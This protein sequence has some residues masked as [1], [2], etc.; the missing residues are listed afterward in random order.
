MKPAEVYVVANGSLIRAFRKRG[1]DIPLD[2]Q[3]FHLEEMAL[4]PSFQVPSKEDHVASDRPGR[5]ESGDRMGNGH[6][7][8][9]GDRNRAD[10]EGEKRQGR[11]L[12][13]LIERIVTQE[14]LRPW[15]LLAP[16]P[17]LA[18]IEGCLSASVKKLLVGSEAVDL[19]HHTLKD[20]E[21]R[22]APK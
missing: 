14:N 16:Q 21:K 1:E 17:W 3:I 15:C 11:A 6:N 7:L 5:F 10:L 9:H 12:A 4:D 20:I 8:V 22:F 18:R 13:G 19:T 2:E